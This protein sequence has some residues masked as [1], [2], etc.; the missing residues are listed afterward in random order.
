MGAVTVSPFGPAP[1]GAVRQMRA[2]LGGIDTG[3]P[4]VAGRPLHRHA[5]GLKTQ[6]A[7]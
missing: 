1:V 5:A 2:F 7:S 4:R 6:Q 3:V